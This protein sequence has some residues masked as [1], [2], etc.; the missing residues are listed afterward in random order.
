MPEPTSEGVKVNE[1]PVAA[2]VRES[3]E[4][5]QGQSRAAVDTSR[6]TWKPLTGQDLDVLGVGR[7]AVLES[8]GAAALA[9]AELEGEALAL[10]DLE[11]GVQD[12][13]LGGHGNG[14]QSRENDGVLHCEWIME[15]TG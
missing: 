1:S 3:R 13:G 8:N 4:V 7:G 15:I 5:G 14:G 11:V 2:A 9:V 12:F 6:N 10:L